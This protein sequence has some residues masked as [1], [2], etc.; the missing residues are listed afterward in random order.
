LEAPAVGTPTLNIGNRQKGRLRASSIVDSLAD[1]DSIRAGLE[2]VLNP[3]FRERYCDGSS[4]YRIGSAS[5]IIA[6]A[7]K[8]VSLQ[9]L[10]QKSFHD[11]P[12][13]RKSRV[14]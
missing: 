9:E 3:D 10:S 7:L 1:S 4:P 5:K 2:T 12:K 8:N 11:H 14:A 13:D 6:E